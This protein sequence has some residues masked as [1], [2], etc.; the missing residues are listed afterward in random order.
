MKLYRVLLLIFCS[1]ILF[2]GVVN[3]ISA[4]TDFGSAGP[5]ETYVDA[6][7]FGGNENRL[8]VSLYARASSSSR[9]RDGY[10]YIYFRIDN[11]WSD[12]MEE[13][14]VNRQLFLSDNY[15]FQFEENGGYVSAYAYGYDTG[16]VW[17][18]TGVGL[19]VDPMPPPD[20][21]PA[22]NPDPCD[23]VGL[24]S[25][26]GLYTASPG[27]SHESCLMTD[28]SYSEVYWYVASPGVD[29]LGTLQEIDTGDGTTT[30]ATFSYTFPS[31][32]MYTGEYKIT[33]YI[34][35]SD[36]SVYEESYTVDVSA[37]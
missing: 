27:D 21:P 11:V 35:R 36:Q 24:Y 17:H 22:T 23:T 7:R 32:T 4:A 9:A 25:V 20:P 6:H 16:G 26:N 10:L 12:D 30:E 37:D 29:G 28:A 13:F 18:T 33:A 1:G 14:P 34:Y 31:G 8:H 19:P 15:D 5:Y 3:D 2:V